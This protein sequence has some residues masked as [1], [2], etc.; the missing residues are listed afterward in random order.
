MN[1]LTR[2]QF[3]ALLAGA[4]DKPMVGITEV[5]QKHLGTGRSAV[6]VRAENFASPIF[7]DAGRYVLLIASEKTPVTLSMKSALA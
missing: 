5:K 2:R 6:I 3:A 1:K 7:I 4:L